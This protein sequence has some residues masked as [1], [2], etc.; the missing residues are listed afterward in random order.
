MER[1]TPRRRGT[2]FRLDN[3]AGFARPRPT[4]PVAAPATLPAVPSPVAASLPPPATAPVGLPAAP[5]ERPPPFSAAEPRSLSQTDMASLKRPNSTTANPEPP[6]S[7]IICTEPASEVQLIQPCRSCN[8]DYCSGCLLEMFQAATTDSTRMPP[9]CCNLLQLHTVLG[10][11][12]HDEATTYRDKFEEWITPAKSYCPSPTCSA[13]IPER[14]LPSIIPTAPTNSEM[15]SLKS[16]QSEILDQVAKSSSARFFREPMDITQLPGYTN[17][18]NEPMDL[19]IVQAKLSTSKYTTTA[20]LTYDVKLIVTNARE[21][22]GDKHPVTRAAEEFFERY[23]QEVT[24]ATDRLISSYSDSTSAK[25]FPCPKCHIAICVSCRQIE[26]SGSPCDTSAQ[27]HELAMLQTFG[28]KRCPRCKA[29]VKKMYGCSHMQCFCGAHWC[30]YCQKSL[31]HCDGSCEQRAMDEESDFDDDDDGEVGSELSDEDGLLIGLTP[32]DQAPRPMTAAQAQIAAAE[33]AM[34]ATA[35]QQRQTIQTP[36]NQTVPT[37]QNQ[38]VPVPRNED[39][40][41]NLDA[42]GAR[43]WLDGGYN[44]G[45]EPED[46]GITQVWSCRHKFKPYS[47]PPDDGINRGDL[48][49]MEC[50]RCFVA[51]EA[52]RTD[53]KTSTKKRRRLMQSQGSKNDPIVLKEEP[54]APTP[55]EKVAW[56]CM[57]CKLVACVS[58]KDKYEAAREVDED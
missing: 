31:D 22:N 30:Y 58:C 4:R 17:V 1:L 2:Q 37:P 35:L 9:R 19:S 34:L 44:F 29:G 50:N 47:L 45:E 18:V 48:E 49:N 24:K 5:S 26:H 56:E 13:F 14:K 6:R 54:S 32:Q 21:Y 51:V 3:F 28:Y 23:L 20:D 38:T 8:T 55:E 43:R 39:V 36:Q 16:V 42:G 40:P 57:R 15:P 25:L 10:R 27:D 53:A 52:K 41:V 46:E 7:C 12:T 33:Q 11:L